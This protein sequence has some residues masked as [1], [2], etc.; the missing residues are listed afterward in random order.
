MQTVCL[1]ANAAVAGAARGEAEFRKLL[2][3]EW[4]SDDMHES[5]SRAVAQCGDEG[6]SSLDSHTDSQQTVL[7]SVLR[8]RRHI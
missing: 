7:Q 3:G 6:V 4:G 8:G 5:L 2:Q 1:T